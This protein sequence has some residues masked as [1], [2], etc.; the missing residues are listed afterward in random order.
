MILHTIVPVNLVV[1]GYDKLPPTKELTIAGVTCEVQ[2]IDESTAKI[3]RLYS[4]DPG[5]F[6]D[7][8]WQPG[9]LIR[10]VPRPRSQ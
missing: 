8:R 3:V 5:V 7:N 1:D 9:T 2:F 4:T 6:L 10:F